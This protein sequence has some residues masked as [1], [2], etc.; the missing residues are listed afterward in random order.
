ME[1]TRTEDL[2]IK[3]QIEEWLAKPL[4]ELE[5]TFGKGNIDSTTFFQVAQRL[6]SKGMRE[7]S[8]EDRLTISTP[9]H[10]RYTIQHIGAIQ[11][12]CK[13]DTLV[14]KSFVAMIKDR[15]GNDSQI[16]LVEYDMVL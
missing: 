16:D 2:S 13:E 1:L 10:I 15:A 6:R 8:Q 11:E 9:Q 12:Y 5:C 4:I 3:K 7:L 14:G